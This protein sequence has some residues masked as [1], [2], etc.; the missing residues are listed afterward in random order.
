MKKIINLFAYSVAILVLAAC[1]NEMVESPMS[2]TKEITFTAS[3]E[4]VSPDT[5]TVRMED[6]STWWNAKEE[7]SV[8]YGSGSDGGSKF[9]STNNAL[10]EI[11]EFSGSVTMSGSGKDFWAVYPYSQ[12]NECD[13]TSI[14]TVIPSVQTGV[15]GNFSNDTF[16]TV[17]KSK[18][19][20]LAFW[21][22]CGGIKFFVSRGD[23]KSVS[24][25][26]NG[27]E[28]LAGR[29][30]VE[31]AEDGTP[32]ISEVLDGTSEVTL[33]APAGEAFKPGKYYYFT[34]LPTSL[35]SGFSMTFCTSDQK[36]TLMSANP[37]TIK[38]S[39]FGVLKNIDS[40]VTTWVDAY[41]SPEAV[42]LGLPSGTLWASWNVGASSPEE[43]GEYFAWGE[44][45]PKA[46]YSWSTYLWCEGSEDTLKKYN[47][48]DSL[49][50]VDS[51]TLL[52]ME[53]DAARVLLGD[54][55]RIPTFS[56]IK[57]LTNTSYCS[58]TWT[59]KEN[60]KGYL[61]TSLTNGNSIFIPAAGW[62]EGTSHDGVGEQGLYWCSQIQES[63]NSNAK[64]LYF[65][66]SSYYPNGTT[67]YMSPRSDGMS[68]R[69][70]YGNRI[71]V[72]SISLS[73]DRIEITEGN[74]ISISVSVFPDNATDKTLSVKTDNNSAVVC[75]S[76]G[77]IYGKSAGTATV[78]FSS[79][80]GVSAS[81]KV[82]VKPQTYASPEAV[83]LGLPSGTLW[84]SFNLGASSPKESGCY[85]AWGELYPKDTYEWTNYSFRASGSSPDD[86]RFSK[87]VAYDEQIGNVDYRYYLEAQD[88]AASYHLGGNWRMP[89]D[90]ELME[91]IGYCTWTQ[92]M[93]EGVA[94]YLVTSNTNGNSIFMP[95]GG[96]R[97]AAGR[98]SS[99]GYQLQC[100]SSLGGTLGSS[101]LTSYSG[102]ITIDRYYRFVGIPIRPVL[103]ERYT[104]ELTKHEFDV[105]PGD[106]FEV[107]YIS[108]T[109]D[110]FITE[111]S[112]DYVNNFEGSAR[113]TGDKCYGV[114]KFQA[115]DDVKT[116]Y[117]IVRLSLDFPIQNTFF[118]LY[119]S[120]RVNY[121]EKEEPSAVDL[122][123]PSGLKWATC[124]VGASKPEEYG[125]Y[126]AW[127]ETQPKEDYSWATYKWCNG[128]YNTLT[129]YNTDSSLGTLDNKTVLDPVDDAAS[130][131]WAGKWRTPTDAEWTELKENCTWTWTSNYNGTDVAG[132]VVTSNK[133][134]CTGQSI[135]LPAAGYQNGTSLN[136]V[137]P[138]FSSVGS[139]GVYWSSS[140][141]TGYPYFA[142]D[143]YF[144]SGSV[145]MNDNSERSSGRS[146]RPVYDDRIYPESV[147][148][149]KS[150]LSL[151][152]GD[153]EQLTATVLPNNATDMTLIWTSD[154]E[155][156]A[157]VDEVG[158][159]R[160]IKSGK[161]TITVTTT[162]GGL[163]ATCEVFV[164]IE[165]TIKD[166]AIE[167][168]KILDIWE[169]TTGPITM[170]KNS[171][172][173]YTV[174]NAHYV[175]ENTTITVGSKTYNTAD[176][177]ETALRSYLLIRGYDGL[178]TEKYGKNSI[179]A[180]EGGAVGMTETIVP[181]IHDYYWGSWPYNEVPGNG[182]HLV[183]GTETE[184]TPCQVKTDI[185]DNWAMRSLNFQHGQAITN[186]CGYA[187]GQL[188]G[189][190]G[191]FCSKRALITYAFFF[192][193]ML[194]NNLD[195]GTEVPDDTIIRSELF[196][197]ET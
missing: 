156:V 147:L 197:D 48:D 3:R 175:P 11:V 36:G 162:L 151:Y 101:V 196:G 100:G 73:N 117:E 182:G 111:D 165:S 96:R 72:T 71:D 159:V 110:G 14:T 130:V 25:K 106:V 78:T 149:N 77:L 93:Q 123:L 75:S 47:T 169:K 140:L 91:L 167:Y 74:A 137:D 99:V 84:A 115:S 51:N 180:L 52:N 7:I 23:I 33:Y 2:F 86:M 102:S 193:Y 58:W 128:S 145:N 80:S 135:F 184:N 38:R 126:F 157:T 81:C 172:V 6:G 148:L 118:V 43:Q 46:D 166:F 153:S 66:D 92:T 103:Q 188:P 97:G 155:D 132:I 119:A 40:R 109:M 133:T 39:I 57:E 88:D 116:G 26:S 195:K 85:Y 5:K 18:T 105:Y 83:D 174:E 34:L 150:M 178:E 17:A 76:T 70:V 21:N 185:L 9:T 142:R 29:V 24:F 127:G 121:L 69:P 194:D 120:F 89:T 12:D 125:E 35:E 131:N 186:F 56:E 28:N 146:V 190:Y 183:M 113:W 61:V 136:S 152:V 10:L 170:Y 68:I 20:D 143:V 112:S 4:G 122:G 154:N 19:M 107:P 181:E 163:T 67:Y 15:D 168:V 64:I 114:L 27:G 90:A 191:C 32:H 59:T 63:K 187:Y 134:G 144:N 49:D 8:F 62:F 45:A 53:D 104:W 55:W 160:A 179:P 50:P 87:Y 42:D 44:V 176:M 41:T 1:V 82:T 13:G 98:F 37:Q 31:F 138:N 173:D 94:G 164:E 108:S 79:T 158:N 189:Y 54:E 161:A 16:P 177:F 22:I 30:K 60:V 171:E 192:K 129:K 95:F 139:Y 124:N 141:N 65:T